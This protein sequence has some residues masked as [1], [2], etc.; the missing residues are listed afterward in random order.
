MR[1]EASDTLTLS[2]PPA[3]TSVGLNVHDLLLRFMRPSMVHNVDC[4]NC[5]SKALRNTGY[6]PAGGDQQHQRIKS[7]FFRY[8]YIA[9]VIVSVSILNAIHI[10]TEE[11][12]W[13]NV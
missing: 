13:V 5:T 1:L 8:N 4:D 11:F 12:D 6:F 3:D 10:S 2:L 9:K 7:T